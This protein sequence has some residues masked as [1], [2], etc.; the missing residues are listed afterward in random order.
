MTDTPKCELCGEPMPA[1]EEMF[2]FHGYSGNCQKPPLTKPKQKEIWL[3]LDEDGKPLHCA[4]WQ[5]AC[6]EHI[7]DAINEH[8]IEG[9]AKWTVRQATLVP[10][11]ELTGRPLLACPGSA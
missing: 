8:D 4:S 10:N 1:G 3:V 2:K 6:H 7:N 11:V 5:N 9:A